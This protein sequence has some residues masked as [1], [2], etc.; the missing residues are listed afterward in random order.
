MQ[1]Q[2]G[3]VGQRRRRRRR[4]GRRAVPLPPEIT[5][6]MMRKDSSWLRSQSLDRRRLVSNKF[7]IEG[8]PCDVGRAT[9]S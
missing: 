1:V 7:G 3:G 2:G 6:V 4:T 8:L 9:Y 5:G